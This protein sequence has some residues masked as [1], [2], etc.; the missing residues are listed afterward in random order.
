[1]HSHEII[2][3]M[4]EHT[5]AK[6]LFNKLREVNP[7]ITH[8]EYVTYIIRNGIYDEYE[9]YFAYCLGLKQY[10]K[11]GW[12]PKKIV[13]QIT[14]RQLIMGVNVDSTRTGGVKG[15][16]HRW[17]KKTSKYKGVSFKKDRKLWVSQLTK[18]SVRVTLGFFKTEIEA[19]EAYNIRAAEVGRK[20]NII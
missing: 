13:P 16:G 8:I 6:Q 20:L 4:G 12:E 15:S 10:Y 11:E 9:K 1:M 18:D 19:A 5:T 2:A 17:A 3:A 7:D 14:P